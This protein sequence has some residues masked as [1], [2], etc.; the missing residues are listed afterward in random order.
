MSSESVIVIGAGLAGLAAAR[1]LQD[2]GLDVTVLEGRSRIGGRTFTDHALG[3]PVD[4]GASWIHGLIANPLTP[5]AARFGAP[6][7]FTD[8]DNE[9]PGSNLV[10]A[11]DGT[12]RDANAYG[13][14]RQTFYGALLH[15]AASCLPPRPDERTTLAD[16]IRSGL[17]GADAL[18]AAERTGFDLTAWGDMVLENAADN[19][20]I[21]FLREHDF[22]ALDG[23]N[24]LLTHGYGPI[25]NGLAEGVT[26]V[27]DTAV[28]RVQVDAN[29]VRLHT[30]NGSHSASRVIVTVPLGVLQSGRM[31][32]DPPLSSDR[33]EALQRV[34]MGR[35]EKL[36]LRYPW[37]FWP[38][39]P[40]NF[41]YDSA[42]Q[43]PLFQFWLN[44]AHYTAEPVLVTYSAGST[45]DYWNRLDDRD[46][47]VAAQAALNA[48]FGSDVP[49]PSAY[50]RTRWADDP[51]AGGS[52]SFQQV[53][54]RP[55]DRARLARPVGER[56]FFA[57]EH[58]HTHYFATTHGAYESGI[59]AARE[60]LTAL[61]AA[62]A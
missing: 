53:G 51:F 43:P 34:G 39:S 26:V 59:R 17:P 33:L 61:E 60:L 16:A 31:T 6:V 30:A 40:H 54:M 37:R 4:L 7:A 1:A 28:T 56:L 49:A 55:D 52:Y 19:D 42:R 10:F 47:L 32:F 57:G 41:V 62:H 48:M 9:E 12:P 22:S 3:L 21:G 50:T 36:V 23:G 38:V 44:L 14:G 58:T 20:A 27:L 11:A 13:R 8:F 5:L 25:V 18:T 24:W 35:F 29:G 46:L 45:A 2:A 15:L